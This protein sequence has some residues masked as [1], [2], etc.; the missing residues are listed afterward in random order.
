M[1]D[2][3]GEVHAALL[4]PLSLPLGW[5]RSEVPLFVPGMLV[6]ALV[7]LALARPASRL[8]G[9]RAWV[10]CL[11]IMG[12]GFIVAAT[13]TPL[14]GALEDGVVSS[15][16]CDTSRV[17]PGSLQSYMRVTETSLNVVLFMPFGLALGLLRGRWARPL[18]VLGLCLPVMVESAQLLA[19]ALGRGCETADIFDNTLGLVLGLAAGHGTARVIAAVRPGPGIAGDPHQGQ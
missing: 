12:L 2:V 11:L 17:G 7:G 19:P 13:L 5:F 4:G 6:T 9:E 16:T 15:G 10:V 1:V 3:A 8:L 14:V 18:I